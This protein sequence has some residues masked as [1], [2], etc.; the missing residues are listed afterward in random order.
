VTGRFSRTLLMTHF[1]SHS[2]VAI[3]PPNCK[4]PFA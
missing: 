4:T 2:A 3:M 1:E